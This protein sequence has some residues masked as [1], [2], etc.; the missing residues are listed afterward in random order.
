MSVNN[1]KRIV[2]SLLLLSACA[3][4]VKKAAPS[5][6]APSDKERAAQLV[7]QMTLD[8]KISL[9]SGDKQNGFFTV[10]IPRLGIPAV[11]TADGPQGIRRKT[12]STLYPS[13]LALSA[14]WNPEIS[15]SVGAGIGQD[16]KARGAAILLGPG[17]NIYRSALCGRN[18]EYGG[19][20][21]F[22]S[23]EIA[24]SYVQGMQ[25]EGVIA[26][27]KHFACNNQEFARHSLNVNADE[28]TL[29]EIYFPAFKK[30]VQK[31]QVAAIMTSYNP[32]NGAHTPENAWL[33]KENLRQW[34]FEGIVMS[35]W[36]SCYDALGFMLSG[37][38]LE[39]P[40]AFASKPEK[41]K[42]LIQNGVVPMKELDEKCMHLL[43]VFSAFG[44]LDKDITDS[45]I[46]LDSE[47]NNQRS[48]KAALEAPVLLKNQDAILPLKAGSSLVVMGPNAD[49]VPLGGGSGA[50]T[51]PDGRG[52][53]LRAGL[54]QL[55]GF[56]VT[57]LE[58][59]DAKALQEAD[60]VVLAL[61]FHRNIE[62][63]GEDRPYALPDGQDELV[64]QVLKYNQNVVAVV[65]GGGEFGA[66]WLDQVPALLMAWYPGQCG[67]QALAQLLSGKVSPS[68]KLPVTFWGSLDKNPAQ[69][70]YAPEESA[71]VGHESFRDAVQ[72]SDYAEGVFLGYRGVEH[73][74]V[75]P[76][77]PFG[78]G[79]S[80]T[81]FDYSD[82]AVK[83][84][85]DG[86][87][88]SF[89]LSNTGDVAGA[90]VAQVYVAPQSPSL[91]RPAR[92]L[93]GFAKVWLEAGA[94]RRVVIHLD[95]DALAHYDM[96]AHAWVTDPGKYAIELGSS[97]QDICLRK[98]VVFK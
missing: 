71:Y 22:L 21:P 15:K 23:G 59:P 35:D 49:R 37:I 8:E 57:Y 83:R 13:G 64:N 63:E 77:Y 93:K 92:E 27:A 87:D 52:I 41:V 43:Q 48:L 33:I 18:F 9:I 62:H 3:A 53:T 40:D 72:H 78:F 86:Y 58:K 60:V 2:F 30:V 17:L 85:A 45:S 95:S 38:D 82:L 1:V 25:A 26:T 73:F 6:I 5:L 47:E 36:G 61:G 14:T 32:L 74:G 39:M 16:A 24:S 44:L 42:P 19:E 31:G 91:P 29:N 54:E 79:L 28:R 20:D 51:P 66:P 88:V 80:Y 81:T 75:Q 90:E 56:G 46:P 4:P 89:T 96:Y 7:S 34:G 11:Q 94:S 69:A 98:E 55:E 68:G 76:L 70:H 65:Y 67:G 50:V 84:V 97:S 10:G 12:K